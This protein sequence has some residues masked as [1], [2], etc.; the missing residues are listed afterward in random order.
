MDVFIFL[1]GCDSVPPFG[2]SG[3]DRRI[4]F[5]DVAVVPRVSTCSLVLSL[6]IALPRDYQM[7]KEKMDF[8]ILASQVR[9]FWSVVKTAHTII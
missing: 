4:E 8:Y 3:T 2:F 1:T 6:P 7:F 5:D 9:V